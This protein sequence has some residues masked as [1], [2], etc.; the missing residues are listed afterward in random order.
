MP[1]YAPTLT[2]DTPSVYAP[3]QSPPSLRRFTTQGYP[4]KR[5]TPG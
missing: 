2:D 1:V 3:T 5:Q 4:Q